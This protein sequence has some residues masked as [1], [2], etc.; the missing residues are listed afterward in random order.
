V[1]T[2]AGRSSWAGAPAMQRAPAV[3]GHE[4]GSTGGVVLPGG[5]DRAAASRSSARARRLRSA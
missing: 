5:A 2:G 3:A 4:R 1:V